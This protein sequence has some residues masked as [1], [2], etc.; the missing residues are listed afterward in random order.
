MKLR[1][2]FALI[3]ISSVLTFGAASAVDN[4]PGMQCSDTA[5]TMSG[6]TKMDPV[7]FAKKR[8]SELKN[9]LNITQAEEPAWQTFADKVNTQAEATAALHEKMRMEMQSPDLTT[10]DRMAKMAEFMKI[11][12]QHMAAMSEVTRTFYNALTPEQ[13]AI[14][15]KMHRGNMHH[16]HVG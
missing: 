16:K 15:D 11:R 8:L 3:L 1:T 14:F 2:R 13:K 7:A 12:S 9:K 5:A 4:C 6:K 10:P